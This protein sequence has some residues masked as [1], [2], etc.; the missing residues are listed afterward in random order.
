MR[1]EHK[2][3]LDSFWGTDLFADLRQGGEIMKQETTL[4]DTGLYHLVLSNVVLTPEEQ[5]E[6]KD[7]YEIYVA[8]GFT[9]CEDLTPEQ[10]GFL[11][12]IYIM[13]LEVLIQN[14]KEVK[15][16]LAILEK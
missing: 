8:N 9:F 7:I 15:E 16:V 14:T 13:T 4:F 11:H 1:K 3:L 6:L 10:V 5:E 12:R 2:E